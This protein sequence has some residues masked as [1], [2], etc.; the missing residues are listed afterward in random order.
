MSNRESSTSEKE[1]RLQKDSKRS[2]NNNQDDPEIKKEDMYRLVLRIAKECN[3]G[4]IDYPKIFEENS[5]N[6]D[7]TF[8]TSAQLE[9]SMLEIMG[10]TLKSKDIQVLEEWFKNKKTTKKIMIEYDRLEDEIKLMG[11]I[12]RYQK[13]MFKKIND[14]L[15]VKGQKI[16]TYL[17]NLRKKS[18]RN[19]IDLSVL[20]DIMA[21]NNIFTD[22]DAE[23]RMMVALTSG[24]SS[25]KIKFDDFKDLYLDTTGDTGADEADLD[26][27]ESSYSSKKKH[28]AHLYLI[29]FLEAL[30]KADIKDLQKLCKD[31]YDMDE[32]GYVSS[33]NFQTLVRELD[34]AITIDELNKLGDEVKHQSLNKFSVKKLRRLIE[35]ADRYERTVAKTI[36]PDH[37]NHRSQKEIKELLVTFSKFALKSKR[38]IFFNFFSFFQFFFNFQIFEFCKNFKSW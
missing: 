31:K 19:F 24:E 3:E 37:I 36:S 6:K 5:S 25:K 29:N 38:I 30:K 35:G 11:K 17:Q 13:E 23:T 2:N 1:S 18:K 7:V 8:L 26:A 15:I 4:D 12:L 33:D 14:E 10:D 22:D 20:K 9:S 28:W 32:R 34:P 16:D 21:E 27:E